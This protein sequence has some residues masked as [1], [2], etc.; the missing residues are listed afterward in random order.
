MVEVSSAGIGE[1]AARG[2]VAGTLAAGPV[3]GVER[4]A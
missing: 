2:S 4:G 3:E 1:G